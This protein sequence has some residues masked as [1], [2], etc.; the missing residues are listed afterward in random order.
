M[1]SFKTAHLFCIG[2][3]IGLLIASILVKMGRVTSVA[4][5]KWIVPLVVGIVFLI[6]E[7]AIQRKPKQ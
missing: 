7:V 4:P 3:G 5:D 1:N 2:A 6:I